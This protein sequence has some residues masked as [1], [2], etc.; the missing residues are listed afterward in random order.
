MLSVRNQL[1][2]VWAFKSTQV[3]IGW[4]SQGQIGGR[5]REGFSQEV[6]PWSMLQS[7]FSRVGHGG[8]AGCW[9]LCLAPARE[10]FHPYIALLCPY[11]TLKTTLSQD[12]WHY[13]QVALSIFQY[14]ACNFEDWKDSK[15][16]YDREEKRGRQGMNTSYTLFTGLSNFQVW[17]CP[18]ERLGHSMNWGLVEIPRA[19]FVFLIDSRHFWLPICETRALSTIGSVSP[20][21]PFFGLSHEEGPPLKSAQLGGREKA[22]GL[23]YYFACHGPS[24]KP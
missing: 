23:N 20:E 1:I 13:H 16:V 15:H 19:Y 3:K 4:N 17:S 6:V 22:K 9:P 18:L 12:F 24:L 10:G 7:Y 11:S 2:W 21:S 8:R 5:D 14:L